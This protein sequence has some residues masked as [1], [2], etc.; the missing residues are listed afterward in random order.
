MNRLKGADPKELTS[1][2]FLMRGGYLRL[3]PQSAEF[4]SPYRCSPLQFPTY[5]GPKP[6]GF[7]SA[8]IIYWG[9]VQDQKER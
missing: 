7:L 6:E 1:I 9:L 4:P 5:P 2:I 8:C 3:S